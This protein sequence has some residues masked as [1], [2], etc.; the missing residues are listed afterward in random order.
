MTDCQ[1]CRAA[2]EAT[3][4]QDC[5]AAKA[6]DLDSL[7]G[8]ALSSEEEEMTLLPEKVLM[9]FAHHYT[10]VQSLLSKYSVRPLNSKKP[11]NQKKEKFLKRNT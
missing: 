4:C 2:A 3:D 11:A 5:R 1:D 8:V 10:N 6:T 9:S 7:E